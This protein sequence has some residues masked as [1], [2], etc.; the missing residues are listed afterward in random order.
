MTFDRFSFPTDIFAGPGC[1]RMALAG[2]L[3]ELGVK[4]TLVVTDCV[5]AELPVFAQVVGALGTSGAAIAY[6]VYSGVAG[7]PVISQVSAGVTQFKEGQYDAIVAVGG[8]AALDV[9]KCIA[10]MAYH[11]GT[12]LDYE[13]GK[14][15]ALTVDQK[16]P[17]IV[18]IPTTAGTGSE[19]GR[20]AVV[21]EDRSKVKRIIFDPRLMPT[22][23][24]LDAELTI[25]LPAK[26][27]AATGMD[28]LT[29]LLE[30]YL[31]PVDHPLCDG[32][33][34]QGVGLIGRHLENATGF[35]A[36]GETATSAH[37]QARDG[38]LRA[39][40]MGA[41]AFQ[42]G[43]G[44]N[45]SM[46]HALSTVCDLHHGLANG[47][48][49]DIT[50]AFNREKV[51]QRI[52]EMG[53]ELGAEDGDLVAEICRLK[54]ALGIPERLKDVGVRKNQ[55]DRLVELAMAD[56]CH[57]SNCRPVDKRAMGELFR[58]AFG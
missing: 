37:L 48:V 46:A 14:A 27:T 5:L 12:L 15:D 33:A 47:V 55:L 38:M 1:C 18:A 22:A 45:H 26:I 53:A 56:G 11:P 21:S 58:Q 57:Q 35:A 10:L 34:R 6:D 41:V 17:V 8:G 43:L 28:A 52:A 16:L 42:K 3:R 30:A 50:M 44:V 2:C 54:V 24:F 7:N 39:A 13:D 36:A 9:A 32:I 40:M 51:P 20:A 19:V 4:S 49:L 29:H 23:V 31:A 25:G